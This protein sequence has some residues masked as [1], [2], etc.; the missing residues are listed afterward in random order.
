MKGLSARFIEGV[1]G[2]YKN[3]KIT[4]KLGDNRVLED[5]ESNAGLRQGC[6]LSPVLFNI[7]IDNILGL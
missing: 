1:K 2:I 5:F 4:V 6:S 3:V 7:F